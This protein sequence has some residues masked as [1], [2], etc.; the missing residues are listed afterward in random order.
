MI[1]R[2]LYPSINDLVSAKIISIRTGNCCKSAGLELL[3]DI[4]SGYENGALPGIKGI[5]IKSG[6]EL[7]W[8]CEAISLMLSK[9]ER[10]SFQPD[11]KTLSANTHENDEIMSRLK[12]ILSDDYKRAAIHEKYERLIQSYSVNSQIWLKKIPF[13]FFMAEY[14]CYSDDRPVE[15]RHVY[16]ENFPEIVDLKEKLKTEITRLFYLS[17]DDCIRHEIFNHYGLSVSDELPVS[18]YRKHHCFPMLWILEKQ[19][20]SY[21]DKNM[22]V[23]KKIFPIYRNRSALSLNEFAT[24]YS[25]P[26]ERVR[27]IRKYILDKILCKQSP[28]FN[29]ENDW[30]HYKP[31]PYDIIWEEDIQQYID[32]EQSNFSTKFVMYIL[33]NLLYSDDYTLYGKFLSRFKRNHWKHT[34]FVSKKFTDIF[35][36]EKFRTKFEINLPKN[37]SS[38]LLNIEN[39]VVKCNCWKRFEPSKKDNVIAIVRDILIHEFQLYPETDG[40]INIIKYRKKNLFDIMYE[41]LKNNG[42]PM[43]LSEIFSEFKKIKPEHYYTNSAQLRHYLLKHDAIASQNRKSVYVLKEWTHVKSGTIRN[44]IIEFLSKE[45]LPKTMQ[46]ITDHVLQY[47]PETN[48]ASIRTSMFSDTRRRFVCFKGR[49]FGLLSQ[50]YPSKYEPVDNTLPSFA[51]RVSDLEKFIAENNRFPF[52]SSKDRDEKL[53]GAWWLRA[54]KCNYKKTDEY[55]QKELER[56][57]IQYAGCVENKR[58][59]Q[60]NENCETIKRFLLENH[61]I[62]SVKTEN[63]F[64]HWLERAKID[65]VEQRMTELQQQKYLELTEIME[66][67]SCEM[68]L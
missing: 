9:H 65:F 46:N 14:L 35:D 5:G 57:K 43:H 45:K 24:E 29:C 39:Y 36:F 53:I 1:E 32:E 38:Y 22:N 40:N 44:S 12:S 61:K 4:F 59:F 20:E 50:K 34:F 19:I 3:C 64:Y 42:N 51:K 60:W 10:N 8:L 27:Q 52:V 33:Y 2:E 47:F 48:V 25:V 17:E 63:F 54:T 49:L 31:L 13:D 67:I 41:I 7:I 11:E 28:F 21:D 56:I 6:L 30:N 66:K 55:K 26:R 16:I 58:I 15:I 62:P 37:K 18:Y 68:L 23:L